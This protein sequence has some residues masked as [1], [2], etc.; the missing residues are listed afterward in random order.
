MTANGCSLDPAHVRTILGRLVAQR[1]SWARRRR[2][3][4]GLARV[5]KGVR[6]RREGRAESA[7]EAEGTGAKAVATPTTPP[8]GHDA[9]SAAKPGGLDERWPV[10]GGRHLAVGRLGDVRTPRK[11][12]GTKSMNSTP[13]RTRMILRPLQASAR[14]RHRATGLGRRS[15]PPSTATTAGRETDREG[16]VGPNWSGSGSSLSPSA[17][18]ASPSE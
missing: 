10:V 7:P 8:A 16:Q 11:G 5:G 3:R 13:V 17:T 9:H 2:A 4:P 12:C 1:G 6:P 14:Q 18:M 15:T